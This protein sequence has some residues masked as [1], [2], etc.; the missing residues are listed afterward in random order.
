[1]QKLLKK[2]D[3]LALELLAL[4]YLYNGESLS[5]MWCM[6]ILGEKN[7]RVLFTI[8]ENLANKKNMNFYLQYSKKNVKAIFLKEFSLDDMYHDYYTNSV[9]VV[10]LDRLFDGEVKNLVEYSS[11]HFYSYSTLYRKIQKLNAYFSS[12][13]KVTVGKTKNVTGKEYSI[14]CYYASLYQV[15]Y[16][17][18]KM[19]FQKEIKKSEKYLKSIQLD[20]DYLYSK[21]TFSEQ[22]SVIYYFTISRLRMEENPIKLRTV[23][24]KNNM[25]GEIVDDFVSFTEGLEVTKKQKKIER[26]WLLFYF[27]TTIQLNRTDSLPEYLNRKIFKSLYKNE[28]NPAE[29]LDHFSQSVGVSFTESEQNVIEFSLYQKIFQQLYFS[30]VVESL[31]HNPEKNET[32]GRTK[33]VTYK[34]KFWYDNSPFKK[35]LVHHGITVDLIADLLLEHTDFLKRSKK[36]YIGTKK[37]RHWDQYL[38][39]QLLTTELAEQI[40]VVESWGKTTDFVI[41]DQKIPLL[42]AHKTFI[43]SK[44]PSLKELENIQKELQKLLA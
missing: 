30:K 18:R 29:W 6:N 38:A 2:Q 31:Y 22:N 20:S 40:T 43:V 42:P 4:L 8:I 33:T 3:Q 13:F 12:D 23:L 11:N 27:F 25:F 28:S 16:G 15:L 21:L 17:N 5:I 34:V 24:L 9:E 19:K 35:Q 32:G 7:R 10:L 44:N 14:R 26:N 36:I 41:V 1:M 37:G 39:K